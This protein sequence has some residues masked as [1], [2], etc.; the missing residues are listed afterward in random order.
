MYMSLT[1]NQQWKVDIVTDIHVL[2]LLSLLFSLKEVYVSFI[3][4]PSLLHLFLSPFSLSLYR[5]GLQKLDI[6]DY[7][8]EISSD[9]GQIVTTEQVVV[10]LA[11]PD[12]TR[13]EYAGKSSIQMDQI[14]GKYV[15]TQITLWNAATTVLLEACLYT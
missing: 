1:F 15:S 10:A 7:H 3:S 14:E 5:T 11:H 6:G 9:G 4:P 13:V 8:C 12:T 2:C